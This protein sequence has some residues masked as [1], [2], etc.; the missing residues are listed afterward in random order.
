MAVLPAKIGN[1]NDAPD[2]NLAAKNLVPQRAGAL[3]ERAFI[4]LAG[5]KSMS[6][7]RQRSHVASFPFLGTK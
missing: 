7:R 3:F 4:V 5:R 1:L 2:E 6:G